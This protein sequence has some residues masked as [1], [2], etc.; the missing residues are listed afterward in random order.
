MVRLHTKTFCEVVIATCPEM[1]MASIRAHDAQVTFRE[2]LKTRVTVALGKAFIGQITGADVNKRLPGS[3]AA[4]VHTYSLGAR[5][6]RVHDVAET[7]QALSVVQSWKRDF[8]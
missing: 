8:Q 2:C 4:A 1:V 7:K 3:L 6:F 5:F